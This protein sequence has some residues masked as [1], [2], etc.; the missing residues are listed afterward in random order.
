[1]TAKSSSTSDERKPTYGHS[2]PMEDTMAFASENLTFGQMNAIVKKLGGEE[3]ALR[4]LRGELLVSAANPA[5][6]TVW[7]TITLGTHKD[8]KALMAALK[9]AKCKVSDYANDLLGKPAFTLASEQTEVDLVVSSVKELGFEGNA[10]YAQITARALELGLELCPAEVGPAL[11]LAYND[12]P[13]D[14][15]LRIA[16]EAITNSDGGPYI[17][18]VEHGNDELWLSWSCGYPDYVWG[19]DYRFVFVLPRK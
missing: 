6:C 8:Q 18:S 17:F 4:F 10:T 13:R 16:M 15:W 3:G 1:M 5:T 11:R 12:Q 9:T 7:K 2:S 14:E 19:P